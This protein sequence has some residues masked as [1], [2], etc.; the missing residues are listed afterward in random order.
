[1]FEMFKADRPYPL[2]NECF[3]S[4]AFEYDGDS[5]CFNIFSDGSF[6]EGKGG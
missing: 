1:M 2:E 5:E 3:T 6:K 4:N